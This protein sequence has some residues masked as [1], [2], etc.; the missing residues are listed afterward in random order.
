MNQHTQTCSIKVEMHDAPH[1]NVAR[2]SNCLLKFVLKPVTTDHRK[3]G[4]NPNTIRYSTRCVKYLYIS[5]IYMYHE[6][7][8]KKFYSPSGEIRVDG[9]KKLGIL[10]GYRNQTP[11]GGTS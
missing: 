6:S 1:K 8:R 9:R 7:E 2:R 3:S 4:T 10:T 5:D 11:G